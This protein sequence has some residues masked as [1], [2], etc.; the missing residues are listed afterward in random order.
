MDR[1]RIQQ[2]RLLKSSQMQQNI[3]I[4]GCMI[5][6]NSHKPLLFFFCLFV[7]PMRRVSLLSDNNNQQS[8]NAK[9]IRKFPPTVN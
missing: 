9:I 7:C 5:D 4:F 3:L 6:G 1:V 8:H 2:S